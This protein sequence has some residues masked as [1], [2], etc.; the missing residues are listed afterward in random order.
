MYP[1]SRGGPEFA[2]GYVVTAKHVLKD[3]DGTYLKQISIRLNLT[4]PM[5]ELG[6][7]SITLP[8]IDDGGENLIWFHS[9]DDA[10]DVAAFPFLPDADKFDFKAIPISM[11]ADDA[12]MR[13]SKVAEGDSLYF[14]GLMAQYYGK[15]KNYPVV[16]R[17]TL[18]L[19]TDEKIE[20]PTGS[21]KAFI[22]ELESC[23]GNS[24]SPVFLNLSGMRD[25]GLSLG[26]NLRFLGILSG[27]FIN[28]WK[29]TILNSQVVEGNVLN[30]GISF[31]VPA[32][33]VKAILETPSAQSLR[34]IAIQKLQTEKLAPPAR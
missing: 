31:I 32:S 10:I 1:D 4:H 22:A 23:L 18:A 19:M 5:E 2:F 11:F 27:S 25:G 34:D 17:G 26:M 16:R 14:I 12:M 30:T 8:V 20:T 6:T 24:G 3:S 33:E 7:G 13:N 28:A 15:L 29:G 21:Q 9:S